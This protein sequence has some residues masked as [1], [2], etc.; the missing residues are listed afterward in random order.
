MR[1]LLWFVVGFTL[2][3][4]VGVYLVSGNISLILAISAAVIAASLFLIK[5][6]PSRIIAVI[7]FG[8]S[9]GTVWIYLYNTC[10]LQT[11]K[12]YD[13]DMII[14][15]IEIADYSYETKYGIA[16]EGIIELENKEYRAIAYLSDIK[17]LSPG[18]VV[19]G[20]FRLRLTTG[21][22]EQDATYHQGK[23]IFLLAYSEGMLATDIASQ[24]PSKYFAEKLRRDIVT[25]LK[26]VFPEDTYGFVKALLLGDSSDLTYQEDTAFKTSGVRHIIA[27]SGL[28]VAILFS[29]IYTLSGKHRI[30]TSLIGIPVLVLFCAVAG[31]TPSVVR[32]CIMQGLMMLSML[33]KREYDPP[34]SLAFAVLVILSVNPMAITSVS[35]QLSVGCIIGIFLLNK[36]ISGYIMKKMGHATGKSIRARFT[37]WFAGSVSVTV[38]ATVFTTPLS[39]LYFGT[40]SIVGV[41]TNLLTLWVVTFIFYGIMLACVIGAIWIPAGKIIAYIISIPV[42]YVIFTAK[43]LSAIPLAAVYT[44]S[45]YI[46]AWIA[47]CYVLLGIFIFMKN[48]RPVVLAICVMVSFA[49]SN[50]CSFIEPRLDSV[51][52]TVF[53]VG[54]GQSVLLQSNGENY[55]VDCGGDNDKAAADTVM[56]HLHSQGIYCLD[57]IILTHYDSDHAGGVINLLSQVS[58]QTLYLPYIASDTDVKEELK[59]LYSDDIQWVRQVTNL[60]GNFG[61]LTLVPGDIKLDENESGLCIL[62]QA[63]N[64]D[65]LI[66]GDRSTSGEQALME[67]IALP[68]L[69]LLVVGHHGA[70]SSTGYPLLSKTRPANAV[71][72][73]GE[74]NP[75]GHPS[76]DVLARL[77]AF[78][79]KISRTDLD[80]TIIFRG[81]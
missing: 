64:C 65:I 3:C 81:R 21:A 80:G 8:F 35:F 34:T 60:S 43:V 55:L 50:L 47:V 61:K 79:T 4:I 5:A 40:V 33:A 66:T 29:L 51:R 6:M 9:L 75:Y 56:A 70:G 32:A 49:A 63:E 57:G 67:S 59:E 44:C 38:G 28:H 58:A 19:K 10:Y 30:I 73:V 41:I 15:Q 54:Q 20:N 78:G 26:T 53:D 36:P 77:E 2:S 69:E 37:R 14:A 11:A 16:A 7:L 1:K 17:A 45:I 25:T 76:T 71:I 27:V 13:G 18:D 39:A 52:V 74:D 46:V 23:G 12:S 24:V 68:Q 31:F 42:R 22:G 72:S 62:F 48:R